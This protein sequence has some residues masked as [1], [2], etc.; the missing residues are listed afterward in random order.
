MEREQDIEER[1]KGK[2]FKKNKIKEQNGNRAFQIV[3]GNQSW[4]RLGGTDGKDT[5]KSADVWWAWT[6]FSR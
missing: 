1:G 3:T 2:G 6:D 5:E 4:R